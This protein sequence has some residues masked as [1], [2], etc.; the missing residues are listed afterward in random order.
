M[1][2]NVKYPDELFT[3]PITNGRLVD[4]AAAARTTRKAGLLPPGHG[5]GAD[6]FG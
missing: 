3:G 1:T 5:F 2:C 6:L 4:A